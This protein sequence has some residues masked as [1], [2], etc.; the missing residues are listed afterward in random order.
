MVVVVGGV[1][2]LVG[3]IVAAMTLGTLNYVISSNAIKP[4]VAFSPALSGI[5]DFFATA[6]MAKVMLFALIIIFLQFK[7]AGLFPQKGRTVDA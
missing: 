1:G 3:S 6:S 7:P 4:F 5:S 2:K